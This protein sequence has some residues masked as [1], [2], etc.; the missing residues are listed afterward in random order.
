VRGADHSVAG[1]LRYDASHL[2]LDVSALSATSQGSTHK[3]TLRVILHLAVDLG[4]SEG[5]PW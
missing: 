5:V 4:I 2:G 1:S 3:E